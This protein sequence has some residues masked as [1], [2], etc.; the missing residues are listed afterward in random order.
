MRISYRWL[1]DWV[2]LRLEPRALAERLTLAGLEVD[3]VEP[4]APAL[5]D[6]VVGRVSKVEA[7]PSAGRLRVCTV[8]AGRGRRLRVV[9]GA[10]NVA[11]GLKAPLAL[12]GATLAGGRRIETSAIHGVESEG[13]L[14]SA[15]E[16]GLGDDASG[17][18]V[19]DADAPVGAPLARALG[20]DDVVLALDL[21]P[22]RGDCLSV[23]GVAREVAALTG[24]RL[25][26]PRTRKPRVRARRRVAVKIEARADCPRYAGRVVQDIDPAA[27]TPDWMRERLRRA[28]VRSL[29]PVVDIT[30]YVMLEL[31]QPM[32]A[33]DLARLRGSVRVRHARAG[34]RLELLDGRELSP[35][36]GSLLIADE[37]GPIAL[38]GIM[39]GEETAVSADTRAVFFESAC[40]RPE[41]VARHARAL[42]I[43]TES[44]QR[45]ERG[46]DPELQVR[47][48]ERATELLLAIAGGEPGAV[49]EARGRAETVA[50]IHLRQARLDALIGYPV[51]C[52]RAERALAALGMRARRTRDGWRVQPPPY[53]Y[54]LRIEADLIEEVARVTGYDRVPVA[55]PPAPTRA[56]PVPEGRLEQ[57]RL[58][59]LMADRDYQEVV[60]YSFVDPELQQLL[61]PGAPAPQLANPI[62][63]DMAVMRTTLWSG[64]LPALRYNRNRQQARVRLFELGRRFRAAD[65]AILEEAVLAGAVTGLADPE[66]WGLEKRPVDFYDVKGDV[67]AL[68]GLTGAPERF[69]FTA[70]D[71]PALHPG[72]AAAIHLED[73]CVGWLGALH[74]GAA[75]RLG[76]DNAF[77]FE[78]ALEAL[79]ARR[80]PAHVEVSRFPAIRRDLSVVVPEEVP[81]HS[82]LD[83][84]RNLAGSLL[85]DLQLFDVYRGEGIDSG[86]KSLSVGLTLQDS[87]RTLKEAEVDALLARVIASLRAELG[88]ELRQ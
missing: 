9:C 75:A 18:L 41:I 13:M 44:S 56:Q 34:E 23:A 49:T 20:L 45:F 57:R 32:H 65:G 2:A 10:A 38:A 7:H 84:V 53:R 11:A 50:P 1:R 73:R 64:L 40:F 82:V 30:N 86:S 21:T 4:V 37:R 26:P 27:R 35:P 25:T 16:L 60:T 51:G 83:A 8:E 76:L 72:Q 3:A 54:D 39:G 67:E 28:G 78:L 22:N 66:Q 79:A 77:V 48:L 46:V 61:D 58:R 42:G 36:E 47:A 63:A 52:A 17:L 15:A 6:V 5:A 19:L 24:A 59:A 31:G 33:F 87:S 74:P 85:A 71:H 12:P 43:Q 68:L 29:H 88:A 14:C 81:A 80:V 62:S 55:L 70:G 69:R